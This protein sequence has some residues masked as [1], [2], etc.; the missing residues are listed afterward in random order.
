MVHAGAFVDHP[1]LSAMDDP[2]AGTRAAVAPAP[3]TGGAGTVC[4][5]SS[6]TPTI[7]TDDAGMGGPAAA[8]DV[9]K[10]KD[11][12]NKNDDPPPCRRRS[13]AVM[14]TMRLR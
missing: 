6:P 11:G 3:M 13:Q 5:T 9:G 1:K 8:G 14:T 4:A 2:N 7:V 12:E 10:D